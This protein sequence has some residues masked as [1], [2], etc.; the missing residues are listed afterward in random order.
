[1]WK[2]PG[3]IPAKA[4]QRRSL[5]GIQSFR[6]LLAPGFRRGEGMEKRIF[7]K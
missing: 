1:M 4:K 3:V 7:L 2:P 5:P 6:P